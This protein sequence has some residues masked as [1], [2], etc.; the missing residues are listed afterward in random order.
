MF[1]D[2]FNAFAVIIAIVCQVLPAAPPLPG[3]VMAHYE[4][5][6]AIGFFA[7]LILPKPHDQ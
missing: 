7:H 5:L 6:F 4:A 2:V 1:P 3:L